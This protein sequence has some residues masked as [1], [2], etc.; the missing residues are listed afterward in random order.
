[1]LANDQHAVADP[2]NK[3]NR[4]VHWTKETALVE[5]DTLVNDSLALG[6]DHRFS[7]KHVRWLMRTLSILE[8]VFGRESR[9]YQ[10]LRALTWEKTG[11]FLVGG[12]GDPQGA[13]NPELAVERL[14]Q[15]AYVE[16]LNTA[17]GL[18]L[19]AAD[20]LTRI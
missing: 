4:W 9:Y 10:S 18:L 17:R 19:A 13:M 11:K 15:A 2:V 16:Q 12:P 20:H 8:E 1:M 3:E 7:T 5:L 14:H 6:S